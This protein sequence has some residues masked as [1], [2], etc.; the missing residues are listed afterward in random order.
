MKTKLVYILTSTGNDCYAAML[1][2]SLHTL[3]KYNKHVDVLVVM[4]E[5]TCKALEKCKSPILTEASPLVI[6]IPQEFNTMQRSRYLKTTLRK[7][8]RGAFF[9]IDGDTLISDNLD[10]IDNEI[11]DIAMIRDRNCP[12]PAEDNIYAIELCRKAG[13]MNLE[14]E[15]YFNGG[16]M[17]VRDTPLAHQFF[18]T[19]HNCWKKSLENKVPQDQPALC[20]SNKMLGHPIQELSAIWNFQYKMHGHPIQGIWH[21]DSMN[22]K[23]RIDDYRPKVSQSKIIHYI[24]NVNIGRLLNYIIKRV[25]REGRVDALVAMLLFWPHLFVHMYNVS[26]FFGRIKMRLF[27][28]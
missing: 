21:L 10:Q 25:E 22:A 9:Y 13:F 19:W 26:M 17:F 20:E 6:E 7:S 4:D 5:N 27:K 18:E 23:C 14:K 28:Q 8:V 2:M 12:L 11:A 15:P 16:V 1:L 24:T 3:R